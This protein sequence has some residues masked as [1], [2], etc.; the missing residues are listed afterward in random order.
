MYITLDETKTLIERILSV[1]EVS[2]T[3]EDDHLQLIMDSSEGI[4]NA[5]IASRY[6]I[7]VTGTVAI[8]YL[9]GLVVPIIRFKSWTQFGDQEDVPDAIKLEYKSTMKSLEML[10]TRV[11]S[12]PNTDDK[13]TGRASHITL[14][15]SES[16]IAGY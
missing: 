15:T 6:D 16:P 7:P 3:V 14:S 11:T 13:T 8:D 9:R 12:L 2:G 10:A 4:V 5:A 1:Y